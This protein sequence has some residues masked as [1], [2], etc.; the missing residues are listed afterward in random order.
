M[1]EN[2]KGQEYRSKN[3]DEININI[4]SLISDEEE[5]EDSVS[6]DG[7]KK[8]KINN[9]KEYYV[10]TT[11]KNLKTNKVSSKIIQLN[12]PKYCRVPLSQKEKI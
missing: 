4:D 5:N 2:G 7:E 9:I 3:L 12:K 1:M 6:E 11:D 8:N 10:K